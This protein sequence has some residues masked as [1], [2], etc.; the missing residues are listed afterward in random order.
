MDV[1]KTASPTFGAA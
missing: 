1:R